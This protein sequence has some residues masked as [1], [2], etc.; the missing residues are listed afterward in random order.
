MH[1][2][3]V[4]SILFSINVPEPVKI[5]KKKITK[6]LEKSELFWRNFSDLRNIFI[7]T[8]HLISRTWLI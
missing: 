3:D 7:E 2:K 4:L 6:L 5:R 8:I 1:Q